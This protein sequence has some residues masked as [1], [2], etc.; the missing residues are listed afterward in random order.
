MHN[1]QPP[2]PLYLRPVGRL[3]CAEAA[4][5]VASGLAVPSGR[6]GEAY[7]YFEILQRRPGGGADRQLVAASAF[8]GEAAAGRLIS[9]AARLTA[10]RPAWAGLA[11]DRPLV[12]GI[13]NVTP[14]SF[15]DGGAFLDPAA[16]I[17]QG[18]ALQAAG[19]D[20]LDIGGESTR[21]GAAP[22]SPEIEAARVVP[23][24]RALAAAGATVS[25]D[26]RRRQVM[27]AALDAGARIVNDVTA[28]GDLG[29]LGLVVARRVPVV[30][31]H[32][33]G[34]PQ[35]MQQAP[36]YDMPA[37]DLFDF[38][39]AR[40][41]VCEA[42]GLDRGRVLIDPGI[43]FGKNL[44][45]N[46]A[47]LQ[48]LALLRATGC[49][50]LLGVSRKSFIGTLSGTIDIGDRMAGSLAAGLDGVGRGADV[51]RVHDVAETVQALRLLRALES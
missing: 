13:V 41:D 22:V 3:T 48:D 2:H 31:M 10:P 39:E 29:A 6:P 20:I 36:R 7:P 1:D 8:S 30:L 42:A 28:L 18:L 33:Q 44:A 49:G 14:D 50:V 45:H 27:E 16:A 25:V 46:V 34:E 15:S 38:F 9:L 26:T 40:L 4:A 24:I 23:V 43:G 19:A 12:M 47:L 51:L 17:A 21:P 32:M 35:T 37:L 5:A 11:L